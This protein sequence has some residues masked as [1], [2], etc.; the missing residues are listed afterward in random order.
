MNIISLES[1]QQQVQPWNNRIALEAGFLA[2]L[3]KTIAAIVPNMVSATKEFLSTRQFVPNEAKPRPDFLSK[4]DKLNYAALMALDINVPEG[5]VG[6]LETYTKLLQ[7]SAV[8]AAGIVQDV[9]E[10]YNKFLSGLISN[11][12]VRLDSRSVLPQL[13]KRD[14][15]R[16]NHNSRIDRQFRLTSTN[17]TAKYGKV[18]GRNAEWDGIVLGLVAAGKTMGYAPNETV[19]KSVD[20]CLEL[21]DGLKVQAQTGGLDKT[22]GPQLRNLSESTLSVA[23]EVEFFS[24]TSYRLHLMNVAL[25][26]NIALINEKF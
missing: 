16:Q 22:S 7:E 14:T 5:F 6:N 2:D 13:V 23:R 20:T 10:P 4:M 15:A 1:F 17:D 21:L 3:S 24:I 9:L 11:P 8:H 19:Q 18:I 12:N 25:E 26:R